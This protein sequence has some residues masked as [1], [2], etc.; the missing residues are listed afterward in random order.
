MLN[1]ADIKK[2]MDGAV[3]ALHHDFSGLRTGRASTALLDPIMVDAYGSQTPISQVG[4]VS[5]PDT[6]L[7]TVQVW[8]KGL[9]AYVEKA[10][11]ESDLGLNP[12]LD[13]QLIRLPIPPLNEERRKE[14]AKIASKYAEETKVSIRNVRRDTIDK[15]KRAEKAGDLSEDKMH[16][17]MDEVQKITDEYIKKVDESLKIK[18]ADIMEV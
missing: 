10:I 8:D 3:D 16:G 15:I 5:A 7:L 11:R 4:S 13:G 14:L 17:Q 6:R 12:M 9:V 1:I 18:E 2:R